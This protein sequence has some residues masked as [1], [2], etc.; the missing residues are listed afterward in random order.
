MSISVSFRRSARAEFI[1]AAAWY[2]SERQD[3]GVEFIAE[4][5][6]CVPAAAERP[7]SYSAVYKDIRRVVAKRFPFSVYFRAEAHRIVVLAV[8]H[9]S[10]DTA[11]WQHRHWASPKVLT[12]RTAAVGQS[13]HWLA[14]KACPEADPGLRLSMG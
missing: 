2:E 3:L 5:E 11:I 6:R 4:I 9:G 7:M 14:R 1:E 10:R 13:G 8:F 12:I